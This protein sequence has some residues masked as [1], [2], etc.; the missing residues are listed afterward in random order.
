MNNFNSSGPEYHT[1][2]AEIVKETVDKPVWNDSKLYLNSL[3]PLTGIQVP[4]V[5]NT[6]KAKAFVN[7]QEG[8]L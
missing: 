4:I 3:G 2:F 7:Y 6:A 8:G 5:P 1:R